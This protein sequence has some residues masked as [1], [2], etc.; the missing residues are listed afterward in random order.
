MTVDRSVI[1]SI[2]T[3][4]DKSPDWS[5]SDPA[6][7]RSVTEGVPEVLTPLFDRLG[8]IPTYL[9]SPEVIE[10]P[11][12]VETLWELDRRA[13]LGMHLHG[14]F[15]EPERRLFPSGMAGAQAGAIQRQ[16][17]REIEAQKL[18]TATARFEDTFRRRPTS[19]RAGRFGLSDNSLELLAGLGYRVD[20]SVTPGLRWNLDE[21]VLDFRSWTTEPRWFRY[22]SGEILEVPIS[23]WPG[24]RLARRVDDLPPRLAR[25]A[26][27][28][29]GG[30]GRFHWLRPSWDSGRDLVRSIEG[31]DDRILVVMLHSMEVIPGASPYATGPEQ[32][33]RLVGSLELL[34]ETC[35]A[36]GYTSIGL[37]EAADRF[38]DAHPPRHRV[39]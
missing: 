22:S 20:S 12:S 3:E 31:R 30:R 14:E 16:W 9:L 10:D 38:Q 34:L 5:I 35:L 24:S 8:V 27:G 18:A 28:V 19:F 25:V 1:V 17:P 15:V 11:A 6:T 13:E 32:V 2:D 23:I 29:L 37:S 4:V 39:T 26:R 21:G 36:R 7:F 33:A